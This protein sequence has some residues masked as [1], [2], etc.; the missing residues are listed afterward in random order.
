V[1]AKYLPCLEGRD[2]TELFVIEVE[3]YPGADR[4]STL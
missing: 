1:T 3:R 2:P 4:P